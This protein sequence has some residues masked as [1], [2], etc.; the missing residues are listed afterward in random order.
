MK[1][2]LWGAVCLLCL[3][4]IAV[5]LTGCGGSGQQRVE[6]L[7]LGEANVVK[8]TRDYTI[9]ELTFQRENQSIYGQ[10]YL[11]AE[12][13]T[14]YPTVIIGHGYG[15]TYRNSA[16]DAKAF[17]KAGIASYAFDFCGGSEDSKSDGSMEDMTVFTE[18]AD[19]RAVLEGIKTYAFADQNNLFLLGKSLG[20]QA[21]ALLAPE[22][23]D[24]IKGLILFY[25]YM[26]NMGGRDFDL[27]HEIAKYEG[28]VLIVQ[29]TKDKA[30]PVE[31][32]RKT[33]GVYHSARLV[34]I[35]GASHG[36][37]DDGYRRQADG[38]AI[39]YMT[40]RISK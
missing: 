9:Y 5:G 31:L 40:D 39:E 35:D 14:H 12:D 8:T 1:R 34:E 3:L 22:K 2:K 15:G 16:T 6:A 27:F 19:M 10:L 26:I 33:A 32:S 28:D 30:V 38:A 11:P 13:K 21:A 24:D 4:L 37:R 18:S 25:P 23:Q 20:G 36:F 17:A 7:G 29:G